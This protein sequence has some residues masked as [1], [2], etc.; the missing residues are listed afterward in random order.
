[1]NISGPRGFTK[2]NDFI[3]VL[4]VVF[5][6]FQVLFASSLKCW[7]NL[8]KRCHRF[9]PTEISKVYKALKTTAGIWYGFKSASV[10][11]L[12]T[13]TAFPFSDP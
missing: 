9:Q 2:P 8:L 6:F 7:V 12:T 10:L 13:F 5:Y 3:D 1:M 11:S 4:P